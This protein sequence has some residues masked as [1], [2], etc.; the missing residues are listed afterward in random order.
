[1]LSKA[2][3]CFAYSKKHFSIEFAFSHAAQEGKNGMKSKKE[4][5]EEKKERN[6]RRLNGGGEKEEQR[7][8]LRFLYLSFITRY[9]HAT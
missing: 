8:T 5:S 1:M 2:F 6:K 7:I 9:L 4:S 3:L